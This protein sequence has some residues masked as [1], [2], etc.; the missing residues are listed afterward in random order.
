MTTE[1]SKELEALRAQNERYRI[2]LRNI[3][4]SLEGIVEHDTGYG[5]DVAVS[6]LQK[7]DETLFEEM[8]AAGTRPAKE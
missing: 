2:M 1:R 5:R 8:Q 6:L 7:I 3:R 4:T